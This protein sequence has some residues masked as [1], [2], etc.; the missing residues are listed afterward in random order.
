[1]S[2]SLNNSAESV[3]D[4][5]YNM[6]L[7]NEGTSLNLASL[8]EAF[9][10]NGIKRDDQRLTEFYQNLQDLK[11]YELGMKPETEKSPLS[12]DSS[13]SDFSNI[14]SRN[15]KITS[16]KPSKTSRKSPYSKPNSNNSNKSKKLILSILPENQ[17]FIIT[18]KLFHLIIKDN[19]EI[20]SRTLFNQLVIPNFKKFSQEFQK[21]SE[22]CKEND[23]GK[24]ADYIPQLKSYNKNYWGCSV[25]TI[26]GQRSSYGDSAVPFTMQSSSKPFYY[27]MALSEYGEQYVHK[28]VGLEPSGRNFKEMCL[29]RNNKPH[30]PMINAGAI[31]T[32]GILYPEMSIGDRFDKIFNIFKKA[33]GNKFLAFNNSVFLSERENTNRN[34]ALAHFMRENNVYPEPIAKD[35]FKESLELYF[36]I[37]SMEITVE[38]GAILASTLANGGVCPLSGERIFKADM[39][40]HVLSLMLSCGMND[41]SGQFAF[42]CGLPA[43][44][45]IS[46]AI[47]I[48]VPNICGFCIWSPPVDNHGNSCRGVKFANELVKTFNFHNFDEMSSLK[49]DPTKINDGKN[50]IST[51]WNKSK[52]ERKTVV[53][54]LFAAQ[55]GD[56]SEIKRYHL[57]DIDMNSQDY[58]GRTTLHIAASE[59]HHHI[60]EYLVEECQIDVSIKDRWGRTALDNAIEFKHKNCELQI[61]KFKNNNKLLK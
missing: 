10:E 38:S 13:E 52:Y 51:I 2:V 35:K 36:M 44:S 24:N 3:E 49:K 40:K 43:K 54:L 19:I 58:D 56:L 41:Y 60:V 57:S 55:R 28:H 7:N 39:V 29:D 23:N 45:G 25:C 37:C 27:A 21:I 26:D 20:I 32:V 46:G 30:N 47:M 15:Q 31:M 9:E 14:Y 42:H 17:P 34:F 8:L 22:M 5:I 53:Y 50:E 59:G 4:K 12:D 61:K 33:V 18:R 1:M 6:F 48:V 11:T 16:K